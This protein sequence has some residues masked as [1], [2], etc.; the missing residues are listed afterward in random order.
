[1]YCIVFVLSFLPSFLLNLQTNTFFAK[2]SSSALFLKELST[3]S[4][5]VSAVY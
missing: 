2:Y 5:A 1:M 3:A 4:S